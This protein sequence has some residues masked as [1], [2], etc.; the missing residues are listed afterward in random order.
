M[1]IYYLVQSKWIKEFKKQFKEPKKID[2]EKISKY[3]LT[4]DNVK[5]ED[6]GEKINYKNET[7]IDF[8][9]I[10]KG[11]FDSILDNMNSL[12]KPPKLYSQ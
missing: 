7:P 3:L 8:E 10:N 6:I 9:I 1:E 11:L 12:K 2:K 4:V 5:P